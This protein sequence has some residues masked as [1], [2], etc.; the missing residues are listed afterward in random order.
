MTSLLH[1]LAPAILAT[2]L[3][4]PL[5]GQELGGR[6]VSS[7]DSGA[8]AGALVIL[9]DSV[10]R[11]VSRTLSSPSGGFLLGSGTPGA[12]QVRVMRI[13]FAGWLSPVVRITAGSRLERRFVIEDRIVRLAEIEITASRSRCGVRPGDG[14]V[15]ASLLSEAEKALA[16]TEQTIRRRNLRFRTETFMTRPAAG[17]APGGTRRSTSTGHAI[18]PVVSAAP[19]SLAVWGFVHESPAPVNPAEVSGPVYYAPDARVLFADWFLDS[20]C[21]AVTASSADSH[22]VVVE[23]T[24][25]DPRQ[26]RRDIRGRLTLDRGTLELRTLEF[27]YTGLGRWAMADS[28]GGRMSFRR[29]D[30]G[31][32]IIDRW[33]IRAPIPQVG[34]S[35]RDTTLYGFAESGGRVIEI[36]HGTR[37]R[38]ER[39]SAASKVPDRQ[40]ENLRAELSTL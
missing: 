39:I 22:T 38:V 8:I 3:A 27:W 32:W 16:I 10:G 36:R 12:Y 1:R 2:A 17:G 4:G 11:E 33:S 40:R 5:S 20:H 6:L 30:S 35:L 37:G 25:A 9:V 28:A 7:G 23:F 21:F 26:K 34:A 14:D 29:V 19:E 18:W 24:P 15:I 13:G 31:A